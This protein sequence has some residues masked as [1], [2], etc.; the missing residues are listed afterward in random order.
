MKKILVYITSFRFLLH[1]L[2]IKTTNEDYI[3]EDVIRNSNLFIYRNLNSCASHA[4][5]YEFCFLM[6]F[7]RMFRNIFYSRVAKKHKYY[8]KFLS[9]FAA[10]LP[11]LDI[12]STAEIGGGL[13]VQHGYATIIAPRKM[14]KNCWVNQG[15]T[16]GYTNDNDCPI[17]GDNVI[18]YCGAKILGNIH[19]G[20]NVIIA[21]NAVVVK[22]VPNNC[23]VG[24]VPATI[25]KRNYK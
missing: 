18:V 21:A 16:I 23:V 9:L 11:L 2:Y 3:K 24:G 4:T 10:P 5:F 25:L 20:D 15:V 12:S 6:T 22:D 1:W 14:G 13:I 7:F 19:V 8:S 17:L